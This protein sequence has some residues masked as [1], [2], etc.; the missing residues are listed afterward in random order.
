MVDQNQRRSFAEQDDDNLQ[1]GIEMSL[2]QTI[3]GQEVGITDA[4]GTHF[5]PATEAYYDNDKWAMTASRSHAQEILQNP[6]PEYRKREPGS[7]A[8]IKP[9]LAGNYIPPLI[10]ILHA[11]PIA[12]EAL[13]ARDLLLEDYGYNSEWWD[14]QPIDTPRVIDV[15]NPTEELIQAEVIPEL[16]RHMAFLDQTERAYGNAEALANFN[17]LRRYRSTEVENEMLQIWSASITKLLPDFELRDIFQNN[18]SID[19]ATKTFFS[20]DLPLSEDMLD[21]GMTLYE[22]LD[23]ALW[24]A[25]RAAFSADTFL[26]KVAD[27]LVINAYRQNQRGSGLGIKIPAVWYAD[28]YL[29][30]SSV[31]TKEMHLNKESVSVEIRGIEN[32]QIELQ[33]FQYPR[34]MAK[35]LDTAQLL[36][37]AHSYFSPSPQGE[38][39]DV[40]DKP[41]DLMSLES[42]PARTQY[43][44]IAAE[45][46]AVAERVSQKLNGVYFCATLSLARKLTN[47][48]IWSNQGN[49]LSKNYGSCLSCT[50]SL[51]KIL[52][53]L[54]T[55]NIP[56]VAFPLNPIRL[57]C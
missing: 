14:G 33:K 34:D 45:L 26:T 3:S 47:F 48:K 57:M 18:A 39:A 11:V 20:L 23:D 52:S 46:Q 55:T 1:K 6:D 31:A 27:V 38:M 17:E 50:L 10:T 19:E 2:S 35:V 9:S 41:E 7:P 36:D 24:T 16:Q 8:F 5:G 37:L 4:T 25:H 40:S 22:A 29:Q 15:D 43:S 51:L 44:Q 28:R 54:L 12:R 56:Y 30:E 42:E 49:R 21:C 32:S 13:L 53:N